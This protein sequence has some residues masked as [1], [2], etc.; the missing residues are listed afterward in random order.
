LHDG[1]A[2]QATYASFSSP[3]VGNAFVVKLREDQHSE[4]QD[5]V[6]L[7]LSML[8]PDVSH[9]DRTPR[10]VELTAGLCR[11]T[12]AS[13][14]CIPIPNSRFAPDLVRGSVH[15]FD[16]RVSWFNSW[17]MMLRNVFLAFFLTCAVVLARCGLLQGSLYSVFMALTGNA[18]VNGIMPAIANALGPQPFDSFYLWVASLAIMGMGY[19]MMFH[20]GRFMPTLLLTWVVL[21]VGWIIHY[22]GILQSPAFNMLQ[23]VEILSLMG[24]WL[25]G[26]TTK[27]LVVRKAHKSLAEDKNQYDGKW[28]KLV[29]D[30]ANVEILGRVSLLVQRI[31]KVASEGNSRQVP[32]SHYWCSM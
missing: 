7:S 12:F 2:A 27:T 9:T 18:M 20:E 21:T 29:S 17:S 19:M 5:P 6:A 22:F 10:W 25:L 24:L 28:D 4:G 14:H 32:Y 16:L 23:V 11:W 26:F 3:V 8:H 30:P 13:V 15:V 1:T 31:C